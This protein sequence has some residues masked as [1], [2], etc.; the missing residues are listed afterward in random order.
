MNAPEAGLESGSDENDALYAINTSSFMSS[1]SDTSS[2][3]Q[4]Q[5][6]NTSNNQKQVSFGEGGGGPEIV[7]DECTP[8]EDNEP[9]LTSEENPTPGIPGFE[10]PTSGIPSDL[11]SENPPTVYSQTVGESKHDYIPGGTLNSLNNSG[12]SW[13]STLLE[14]LRRIKKQ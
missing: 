13:N 4:K 9:E 3:N 11:H 10:N 7:D 12:N 2:E 8:P 14:R 6:L 1:N 5:D